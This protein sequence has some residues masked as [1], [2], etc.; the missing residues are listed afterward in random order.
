MAFEDVGSVAIGGEAINPIEEVLSSN[1][2]CEFPGAP[3]CGCLMDKPSLL[4]AR[5]PVHDAEQRL[6]GVVVT[7]R[8]VTE[9]RRISMQLQQAQK[10]N[11]SVNWP[12]AWRTTLTTC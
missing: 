2:V 11:P 4:L 9:E 8:D 3:P 1:D 7:M 5:Y 10:R 12:G 6:S